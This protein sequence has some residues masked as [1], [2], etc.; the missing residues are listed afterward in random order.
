M[1]VGT[2]CM[3]MCVQ[4]EASV[5]IYVGSMPV[6]ENYQNFITLL[7]ILWLEEV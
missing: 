7:L 1:Y 4:Y 3:Y 6:K 5:T 2:L